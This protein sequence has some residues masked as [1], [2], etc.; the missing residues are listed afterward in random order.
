MDADLP[1]EDFARHLQHFLVAK[2]GGTL[3]GVIGPDHPP[4]HLRDPGLQV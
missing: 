4:L 3:V 1:A 2:Q